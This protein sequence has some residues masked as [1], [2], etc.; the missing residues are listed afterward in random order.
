MNEL[1]DKLAILN[2]KKERDDSDHAL[3]I[4]ELEK[5]IRDL[6]DQLD[7][8]DRR[9]G[10]IPNLEREIS[11]LRNKYETEMRANAEIIRRLQFNLEDAS[12][13]RPSL[14]MP[15][16]RTSAIEEPR[17][18]KVVEV[19]MPPQKDLASE[20][21]KALEREIE[22]A[23]LNLKSRDDEIARLRGLVDKLRNAADNFK[24]DYGLDSLPNQKNLRD[25]YI[26]HR[27]EIIERVI[28]LR[29]KLKDKTIQELS[30]RV[31]D[32][33]RQLNKQKKRYESANFD[34]MSRVANAE[35]RDPLYVWGQLRVRIMNWLF[36]IFVRSR[37]E[38]MKSKK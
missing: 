18:S 2:A 17:L 12:R 16:A 30:F 31:L 7:Q 22:L 1:M 23:R 14:P 15:T 13:Y 25:Y 19:E 11:L 10:Q 8:K 36:E 34:K 27:A 3:K 33:N 32:L 4:R 37:D 9:L 38:S 24:P 5:L 21:K 26:A 35:I 6:K 28:D 29:N 20:V